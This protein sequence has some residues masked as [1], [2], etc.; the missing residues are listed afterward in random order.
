MIESIPEDELPAIAKKRGIQTWYTGLGVDIL[1][2]LALVLTTTVVPDMDNWQNVM[3][4]WPIWLLAFT[5]SGV[6]AVAAW[7]LRRFADHSGVESR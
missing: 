7:A 2:A 4:S 1:V 6:Q 5:R 3:T